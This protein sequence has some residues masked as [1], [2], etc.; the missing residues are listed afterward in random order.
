VSCW[1]AS[2]NL[3]LAWTY[4]ADGNRATQVVG[5]ATQAYAYPTTSNQL[6]GIAETG[7]ATRSFTYDASGD[8]V[9]DAVGSS[10]L[11]ERYDGHGHLVTVQNGAVTDGAF[12]SL[13][14]YIWLDDMPIGPTAPRSTPIRTTISLT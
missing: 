8:R 3:P 12:N 11:N 13:R 9:S 6:A 5:S 10:V 4:D 14:E 2:A 1:R 7:A